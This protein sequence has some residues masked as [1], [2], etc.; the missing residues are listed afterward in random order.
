[1]GVTQPYIKVLGPYCPGRLSHLWVMRVIASWV[2]VYYKALWRRR[3]RLPRVS[4]LPVES[5]FR[6]PPRESGWTRQVVFRPG[7]VNLLVRQR[8]NMKANRLAVFA[9]ILAS[10]VVLTACSS[11]E[12]KPTETAKPAAAAQ[13]KDPVLYTGQE[14]FNKMMLLAKKWAPDALPVRLES[15]L[16]S[17]VTGQGGKSVMW[18]G[19]FASASHR[20]VKKFVCSG[21]REPS[22]PPVGVSSSGGEETYSAST[23]VAALQATFLK[24]DSDKA[25]EIAQSHGGDSLIKENA[26]Q[27]VTYMLYWDARQNIPIW[28]VVYGKSAED[29]D[30]KAVGVVNATTGSF[31]GTRK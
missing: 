20:A 7:N 30:R 1:L 3:S 28:N 21:S 22:A 4:E 19:Y 18:T 8:M 12:T 10:I 15:S 5:Y 31:M 9:L 26:K 13:S 24:T 17:E 25:Y 29:K 11:T 23:N 16:T 14:A 27:P 2:H 6:R